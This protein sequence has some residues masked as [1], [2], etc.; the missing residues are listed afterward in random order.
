MRN[1]TVK[2]LATSLILMICG[3]FSV[4]AQLLAAPPELSF[5]LKCTLGESCW[6]VNFVDR[7]PGPGYTDFE[8]GAFSYNTHKG[9]DIAIADDAQMRRGVAV[10][11]A[12]P[13][14]VL[15]TRDGMP[16]NT[17]PGGKNTDG[18]ECGNGL[19]IDHGDG[20]TTQYCHMQSGSLTVVKG[21]TVE[22]GTVLGRIGR[23]GQTEFPHLHISV[24]H[25]G[26]V[27]D[28]FT[29]DSNVGLCK[30]DA[31]TSGSLWAEPIR[32]TLRYPGPQPYHLGFTD[33]RVDIEAVRAGKL[34]ETRFAA[35]SPALIFWSEIFTLKAGDRITVSLRAPDG[36]TIGTNAYT[37]PSPKARLAMAA[38]GKKSGPTWPVGTYV[39]QIDITRGGI[40]VS[41]SLKATV[42]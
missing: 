28:P 37:V 39:G 30:A 31:D 35:T 8:C 18:R 4:P 26:T 11:A 22:R 20:W 16:Y 34:N 19:V 17:A 41:K 42:E 5:P 6:L 1:L 33:T 2:T 36:S 27:I 13:G 9:T 23:S 32:S 3:L 14:L 12:A 40:T 25:D 7:D 38:T 24:K 21:S 10:L 29:G 15:G